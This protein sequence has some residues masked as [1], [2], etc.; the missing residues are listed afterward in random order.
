VGPSGRACE[1]ERAESCPE[2]V[3]IDA[4]ETRGLQLVTPR[5]LKGMAEERSGQQHL[6][7]AFFRAAG[8]EL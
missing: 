6:L 3:A 4:E 7:A 2:R 5:Q 1:A 8:L